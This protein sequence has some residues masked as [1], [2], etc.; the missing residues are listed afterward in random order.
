MRLEYD[1]CYIA[2]AKIPGVARV[3]LSNILPLSWDLSESKE[4][5]TS[6][7]S[8]NRLGPDQKEKTPPHCCIA[9]VFT[10]GQRYIDT[11]ITFA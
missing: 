7:S 11:D 3:D 4:Q 6:S 1:L 5:R 9:K 8:G 2:L 10:P